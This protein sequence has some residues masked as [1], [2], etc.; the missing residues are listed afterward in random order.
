MLPL[1]RGSSLS[2][3]T[4]GRFGKGFRLSPKRAIGVTA[5]VIGA[6]ARRKNWLGVVTVDSFL[7]QITGSS[8]SGCVARGECTRVAATGLSLTVIPHGDQSQPRCTMDMRR[9][10]SLARLALGMSQNCGR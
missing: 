7:I 10:A 6:I 9:G 4:P 1:T 8:Q 3:T 5:G 2:G